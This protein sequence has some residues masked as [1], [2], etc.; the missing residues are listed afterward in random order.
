MDAICLAACSPRIK[1][2]GAGSSVTGRNT[3]PD[4]GNSDAVAPAIVLPKAYPTIERSVPPVTSMA[5]APAGTVLIPCPT[6]TLD[7]PT[8]SRWTTYPPWAD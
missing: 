5:M 6:W 3:T 1:G 8:A 7:R 2:T 4:V